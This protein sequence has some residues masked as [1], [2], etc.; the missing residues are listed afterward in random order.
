V[1]NSP[2]VKSTSKCALTGAFFI[3]RALWR[4]CNALL[5]NGLHTLK[6]W[7]VPN[8][9]KISNFHTLYRIWGYTPKLPVSEPPEWHAMEPSDQR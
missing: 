3:S 2:P 7:Q 6:N 9:S 4:T 1:V 8:P 5:F